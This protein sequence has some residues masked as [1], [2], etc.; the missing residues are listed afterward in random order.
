MDDTDLSNAEF[1]GTEF[2]QGEVMALGG[3]SLPASLEQIARELGR[4]L[5]DDE[6]SQFTF[7]WHVGRADWEAAREREAERQRAGEPLPVID[8][9]GIPY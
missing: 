2:E 5:T 4:P 8:W 3:R 1:L 7:G 9:T 6:K